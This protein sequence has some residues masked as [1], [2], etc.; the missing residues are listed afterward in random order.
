MKFPTSPEHTR[1]SKFWLMFFIALIGIA[2]SFW[3]GFRLGRQVEN[4]EWLEIVNPDLAKEKK[5][6]NS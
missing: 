4:R 2:V 1:N 3:S 6:R 5:S